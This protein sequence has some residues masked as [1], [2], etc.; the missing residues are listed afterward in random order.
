MTTQGVFKAYL[1]DSVAGVQP[2]ERRHN[3]VETRVLSHGNA[4]TKGLLWRS[5]QRQDAYD[6]GRLAYPNTKGAIMKKPLRI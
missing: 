4:V 6:V 3:I 2:Q 1:R 5:K